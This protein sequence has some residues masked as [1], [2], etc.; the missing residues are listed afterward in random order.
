[1][2]TPRKHRKSLRTS[3]SLPP[4]P[5]R[6]TVDG[7][8][9]VASSRSRIRDRSV[10]HGER[11]PSFVR[12]RRSR[13]WMRRVSLIG[14]LAV[15]LLL[16]TVTSR[17]DALDG[18]R[19]AAM[20]AFAPVERGLSAAWSPIGGAWDWVVRLVSATNENPQLKARVDELEARV[21]TSRSIEEENAR[22]R[23]VLYLTERGRFPT[24]Y[25]KV[26][27]S[28]IARSPS[29]YDR[30]VTI[31]LG[32]RDGVA[33]NDPVMVTRGLIGR[34]EAVSGNAA[35][36]GLIT[37]SEQ[38]VSVKVVDSSASGIVRATTAEG[39]P[40]ME[41]AYVPQRVRVA[42]GD[43]VVTSGWTNDTNSLKSIYPAGIPVGVVTS[44][45][46]SPADLY[47][48]I[49]VTPFADFD[50]IDHV[51]VLVASSRSSNAGFEVP[52]D[53]GSRSR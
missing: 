43:L 8:S 24:G 41:L 2:L 19:A 16:I 31:D 47:K 17:V 11:G 20:Q 27:G 18:P 32:R 29:H 22:L 6:S 46:N 13:T 35:R 50:R 28:V 45:G 4:A 30:S 40:A 26:V 12:S 23:Q 7:S 14:V 3:R 5:G 25:R 37:N 42:G 34:I 44:V 10:R 49:Q 53:S 33:V 36:V 52:G 1:M 51:I 48:T 21:V 39:S 38:A 15:C 9:A